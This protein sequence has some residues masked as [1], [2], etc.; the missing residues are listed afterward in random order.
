MKDEQ[1]LREFWKR[2]VMGDNLYKSYRQRQIEGAYEMVMERLRNGTFM[3]EP[4]DM[5]DPKQAIAAAYYMG[6][7]EV[8]PFRPI[9]APSAKDVD[10]EQ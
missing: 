8:V 3:G 9:G 2:E 4:L 5:D 7:G 6:R 1:E 10:A